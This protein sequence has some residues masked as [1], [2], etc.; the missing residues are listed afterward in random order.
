MVASSPSPPSFAS[1]VE[2]GGGRASVVGVAVAVVEVVA[3][4]T[5]SVVASNT[6]SGSAT[7]TIVVVVVVVASVAVGFGATGGKVIEFMALMTLGAVRGAFPFLVSFATKFAVVEVYQIHC[8]DHL[9]LL[10]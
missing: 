3:G 6:A 10:S 9:T 2:S 4:V 1:V 7:I 8:M 5:A